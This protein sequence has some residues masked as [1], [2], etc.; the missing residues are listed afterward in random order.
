[1][2][3]VIVCGAAGAWGHLKS[4]DFVAQKLRY[5]KVVERSAL[6]MGA[7]AGAVLTGAL[8]S[9]PVITVGP[10]ALVGLGVGTGVAAGIKRA[11]RR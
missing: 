1:M 5:T 10:A 11:R 2:L 3:E 6:G 4:K 8:A 7:V 9:L